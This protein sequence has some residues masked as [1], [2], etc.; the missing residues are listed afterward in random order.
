V[1][2]DLAERKRIIESIA[3]ETDPVKLARY[4]A[5]DQVDYCYDPCG[6]S[7]HELNPRLT[8][9]SRRAVARLWVLTMGE[10]AGRVEVPLH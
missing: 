8:D 7:W 1:G 5:L 6:K 4:V 2:A 9:L 10:G 3:T